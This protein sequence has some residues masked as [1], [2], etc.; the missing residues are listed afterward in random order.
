MSLNQYRQKRRFTRTPEPSGSEAIKAGHRFVVQKHDATHLHYD[1]RLELDGTLKSWAVPKGPSLDPAQKRLAVQVEDHPIEYGDFEGTIPQGEY[2]GGTVMVWDRGTWV[3]EG[4]D[5]PETQYREGRLKF[6]LKGEKLRGSWALVRTARGD[7]RKPQWLLIKHRDSAATPEAKHEIIETETTSAKTGRSLEE[8]AQGAPAHK[9]G[10]R[11]S[12]KAGTPD[13]WHSNRPARGAKRFLQVPAQPAPTSKRAP[14]KTLSLSKL[15]GAKTRPMPSKPKAELAS[16]VREPPTTDAWLHEIK[17]DGYRMFCCVQKGKVRFISRSGQDWTG[18]MGSLAEVLAKLPVDSAIIDGEV[19]VLDA[20]GVSQF[21]LL[22]NAMGNEGQKSRGAPL[23]YYAFDLIYLNHLD[24]TGV[25]LETRKKQLESL[26]KH[27]RLGSRIQLSEHVVGNG[28]QFYRQAAEAQLEGIVS[29]KRRSLYVAGRGA[30]WLKSKCRQ[31]E[32]FVIGG[33]T[34]PEGARVG[35]G[36]LLL[37]YFRGKGELIYAGRVGTGFNNKTLRDLIARLKTLEQKQPP[38]SGTHADIPR[39]GVRWVRPELVGQVEFSNWTD[40]GI[41]R[42]A[43]F[44]GLRED[45]PARE[46]V[47]ERPNTT[48]V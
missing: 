44:Q 42:Q 24:L 47:L 41:L 43:A 2:G 8:I 6:S 1:F 13:V 3:P 30:D 27:A 37:G 40:E 35:F 28:R 20:K 46:V 15:P 29:K 9:N 17:F 21:Q 36:A 4:E 39:K 38:F 45:K 34:K 16:L 10:R 18:R 19:V 32:E 33:Y 14:A 12:K 5:D 25:V 11:G 22:Q 48:T 7:A 31:T 26:L 23:L